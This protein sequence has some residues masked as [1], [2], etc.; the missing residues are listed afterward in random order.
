MQTDPRL[1]MA[2]A[3]TSGM[4]PNVT[5]RPVA[6][7]PLDRTI[8]KNVPL[9][10][11]RTH[12]VTE[13]TR[14]ALTQFGIE[15]DTPDE[16]EL[17]A[18][19]LSLEVLVRIVRPAGV[20]GASGG[21]ET[22]HDLTLFLDPEALEILGRRS[23]LS[24]DAVPSPAELG[25]DA[26]TEAALGTGPEAAATR[27][28]MLN[29]H[30]DAVLGALEEAVGGTATIEAV[31]D[32]FRVDA[33]FDDIILCLSTPEDDALGFVSIN[34]TTRRGPNALDLAA[35]HLRATRPGLPGL[36][37]KVPMRATVAVGHYETSAR[38]IDDLGVGDILILAQRRGGRA[39][40]P[41]AIAGEWGYHAT[42]ENE[43]LKIGPKE[44]DMGQI[45]DMARDTAPPGATSAGMAKGDTV[46]DA[47]RG[48]EIPIS[49]SFEIDTLSLT[50]EE[51]QNLRSGHVFELDCGAT[52]PFVTLR[53]NGLDIGT[54]EL[55]QVGD[56]LGVQIMSISPTL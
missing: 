15:V 43:S 9:W 10:N 23:G 33:S 56:K 25:D 12:L 40:Y 39:A 32:V 22:S 50:L 42:F 4:F 2:P 54:G 55:V 41:A 8:Q 38:E 29:L 1:D 53:V 35:E 31:R 45:R 18:S 34:G 36:A 49:L 28:L 13:L 52:E 51:V 30:L 3:M 24:P 6:L 27:V 26:D 20:P 19:N 37:A 14:Q 17:E 44:Y 47:K 7:R 48:P 5:P 21:E 16:L 46:E 11:L